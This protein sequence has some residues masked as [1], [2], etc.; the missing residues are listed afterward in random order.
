MELWQYLL[1]AVGVFFILSITAGWIFYRKMK[2]YIKKYQEDLKKRETEQLKNKKGEEIIS[3]PIFN[4][5]VL[6]GI[7]NIIIPFI[8][9]AVL[10]A[11]GFLALFLMGKS[12]SNSIVVTSIDY[13]TSSSL[14][15]AINGNIIF[16]PLL[17]MIPIAIVI[18][19]PLFRIL[20]N[21]DL[22]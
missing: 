9:I 1:I 13:N 11:V 19:L 6:S 7:R 4:L 12:L 18:L 10:I 15:K 17:I 16:I 2:E 3:Q 22:Y 8:F 20:S 5:D 21:N 14:T